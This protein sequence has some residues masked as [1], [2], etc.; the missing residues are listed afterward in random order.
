MTTTYDLPH[1]DALD[2]LI[3]E[4]STAITAAAEV[5]DNSTCE[6]LMSKRDD[7]ERV[8]DMLAGMDDELIR[9]LA[10][11]IHPPTD[12]STSGVAG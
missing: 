6:L 1:P 5:G 2:G 9:A 10:Y 12:R 7:I 11:A 4:C 8:Q 3:A